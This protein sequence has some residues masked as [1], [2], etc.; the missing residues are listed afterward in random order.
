MKR[1]GG[2][3]GESAKVWRGVEGFSSPSLG[4]INGAAP[5]LCGTE[6][7]RQPWEG[8]GEGE[9]GGRESESERERYLK[10]PTQPKREGSHVVIDEIG[11][12]SAGEGENG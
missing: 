8:G 10:W 6:R 12:T 11:G 4:F 7:V 1:G 2:G 9:W 5:E 3:A